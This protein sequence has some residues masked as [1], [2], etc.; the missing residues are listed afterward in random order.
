MPYV[1]V[2]T[3]CYGG[4][5]SVR[6]MHAFIGLLLHGLRRGFAVTFETL[7]HESLIT[8]G[9]NTL[10]AKF[11]DKPDATHLLFVDADIAFEPAQVER[12]L[13]FDEDVVAGVYPLKSVEW[14]HAAM[15]RV[16]AGEGLDTAPIRY[17]GKPCEGGELQ[18]RDGFVTASHA[19]T[20]FMLI[21]RA[22]ILGM[23]AA[24]PETHYAAAH[25]ADADEQSPNQ[26]ALFDG[27]IDPETRH[28]LSEDYTFCW[29]WRR[30]GGQIWLDTQS[31]LGHVGLH[32][33]RGDPAQRFPAQA[34]SRP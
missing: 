22:A 17:V 30:I 9:R 18:R 34:D 25:A 24:Y 27:M 14:D 13:A 1:F 15:A 16:R 7:S 29:R 3:P 20:G 26:Y 5:V 8:R 21:R 32:E 19:G 12:M 2:A 6:T 31:R 4:A 11:L 23:V 33:F 28:Y 10:V